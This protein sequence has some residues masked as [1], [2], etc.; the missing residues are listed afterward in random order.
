MNNLPIPIPS[1]PLP[2]KREF[3]EDHQ[4]FELV[5]QGAGTSGDFM[6]AT[7]LCPQCR[8]E[9]RAGFTDCS[10][11]QIT[12]I[13]KLP[14]VYEPI[15]IVPYLMVGVAIVAAFV[16]QLLHWPALSRIFYWIVVG[17]AVV[18]LLLRFII[19]NRKR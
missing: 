10:D 19:Q 18:G 5:G 6:R 7:M 13:P 8:A 12:L 4:R 17:M 9:Y 14:E 15:K 3:R 11:C 2:S 1:L 16:V